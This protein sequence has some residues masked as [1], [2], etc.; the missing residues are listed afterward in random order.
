MRN[1]NFVSLSLDEYSLLGGAKMVASF[2]VFL[3][4]T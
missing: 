2:L 1:H 4:S 3:N